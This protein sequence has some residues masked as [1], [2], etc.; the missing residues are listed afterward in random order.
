MRNYNFVI[1]IKNSFISA[2]VFLL[3]M[4]MFFFVR[5]LF[6]EN[7]RL[8]EIFGSNDIHE[9]EMKFGHEVLRREK[10]CKGGQTYIVIYLKVNDVF[11]NLPSGPPI[12][13]FDRYGKRIAVCS[14]SGDSPI[15]VK[16]WL[17]GTD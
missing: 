1:L 10:L 8:S 4:L 6:L 17:T 11:M 5:A 2:V 15:F 16:N 9:F 7:R 13:I 14:D 3:A 12:I